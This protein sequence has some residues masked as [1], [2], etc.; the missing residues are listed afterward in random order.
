[1]SDSDEGRPDS[2]DGSR[3]GEPRPA[4]DDGGEPRPTLKRVASAAVL[5]PADEGKR[6]RHASDARR[7]VQT[8]AREPRHLASAAA[9]PRARSKSTGR[10]SPSIAGSTTWQLCR[11]R[12]RR[13]AAAITNHRTR[14]ER[15][16]CRPVLVFSWGSLYPPRP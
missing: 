15:A 11:R 4:L 13:H 8:R 1:M 12:R 3:D 7:P 6:P 14:S 5:D 10:R 9:S 2:P 16:P